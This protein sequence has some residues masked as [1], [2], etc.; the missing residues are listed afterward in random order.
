[1]ICNKQVKVCN[2][3]GGIVDIGLIT[4]SF[5]DRGKVIKKPISVKENF[6]KECDREVSDFTVDTCGGD[7]EEVRENRRLKAYICKRC[8]LFQRFV[9]RAEIKIIDSF[10][11][12]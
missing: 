7:M 6:C 3:C 4:S 5:I 12:V 9:S 1:M 10:Y 2:Q 11:G 8:G